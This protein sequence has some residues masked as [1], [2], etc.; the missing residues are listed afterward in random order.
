MQNS[1]ALAALTAVKV[2][3]NEAEVHHEATGE[4]FHFYQDKKIVSYL[5]ED[6]RPPKIL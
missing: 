4:G 2:G 6:E 1:S 5:E 3:T